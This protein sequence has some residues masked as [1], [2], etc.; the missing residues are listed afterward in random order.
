MHRRLVLLS[1]TALAACGDL[2]HENPFDPATPPDRQART[3]FS[4]RVALEPVGGVTPGLAG[5]QVSLAGTGFAAVTDA[6]GAYVITGVPPG[7][8]T[9]QAIADDYETG[10][11]AGVTA[12]LDTGGTTLSLPPLTLLR[13]RGDLIGEVRLNL[14]ASDPSLGNPEIETTGGATV[15]LEGAAPPPPGALIAGLSLGP[16]A[17]AAAAAVAVTDASGAYVIPDVP[18][19]IGSYTLTASRYGYV[20]QTTNVTFVNGAF[21]VET[22]QLAIDPGSIAGRAVAVGRV[23]LSGTPDSSG[24]TVRARGTTLGG[25]RYWREA[26]TMVDGSYVVSD[27]PA[28]TYTVSFE[29]PDHAVVTASA[30]VA[31]GLETALEEVHLVHD[32]GTLAGTVLLSGAASSAGAVVTA[33]NGTRSA[34]AVTDAAGAFSLPGLDTGSWQVVARKDPDWTPSSE[35]TVAV[36]RNATATLGATPLQP[37][38]TASIGGQALLERTTDHSLTTV[39]L[40]GTDF[41]GVA[42]PPGTTT[43]TDPSGS[44]SFTGLRAGS[45]Q[46]AFSHADYE[47]PAP[48]GVSLVTGQSVA[49]PPFTLAV[50]TGDV[51]GQVALSAGTA[52]GFTQG[53]D[54]SGVVVT[55]S[56]LPSGVAIPAAVTDASGAYRFRAV[57]VSTAHA[58]YA[59]TARLANYASG[60]GAVLV[61]ANATATVAPSPITLPVNAGS[62]TGNVAVN[63]TGTLAAPVNGTV[64][65]TLAGTAFNGTAFSAS[66]ANVGA[67]FSL[68]NLPAG[69]Y[70]LSATSAGR[71]CSA[72]VGVTLTPGEAL[73]LSKVPPLYTFTCTDAVAPGAVVLGVPQ[74]AGAEPGY[75]STTSVSVPIVSHA[76]D[77][78]GNLA[79]YQY[80]AGPVAN[81]TGAPVTAGLVNPVAFPAGTLT[82]DGTWTLW[83]RAVDRAG[84]AGPA[85]SVGVVYDSKNP[86]TPVLSTARAVVDATS[87][88]ITLAGSSVDANFLEYQ[89]ATSTVAATATCPATTALAFASTPATAALSLAANVKTCFWARA[90]DRAGRLSAQ[91]VLSVTSDLIP[92][93]S[94][95]IAP[96]Y[97]PSLLTVHAEYAD[98]FVTAGA[99]DAPAG[100][101]TPWKNVAWLEVDV[102]TGFQP[103]CPS[104][105]CRDASGVYN[106]CTCSCTDAR[107]VC[108]G[109]TFRA[110]RVPLLD[111]TSNSVGVRAVDLAGNVGS[112]ASQLVATATGN[113]PVAVSPYAENHP[114]GRGRLLGHRYTDVYLR[115]RDLGEDGRPDASDATCDIGALGAWGGVVPRI[116]VLGPKVVVHADGDS[117]LRSR[118]PGADGLFCSPAASIDDTWYDFYA[119][120]GTVW[121]RN[122]TGSYNYART[123]EYAAW[124]ERDQA[125]SADKVMVQ[126]PNNRG[127]LARSVDYIFWNG[128]M[129]QVVYTYPPAPAALFT[130]AAGTYVTDLLEGG[131][132]LLSELSSSPRFRVD[133]RAGGL[134]TNTGVT[135]WTLPTSAIAASLSSDGRSLAWLE[136]SGGAPLLHVR[137]AGA[138]RLYG[139]GDDADASRLAP[140][141]VPGS[142]SMAIE[143]SH[144]VVTEESTWEGSYWMLHWSAGPDGAF[145]SVTSDDD[146]VARVLPSSVRRESPSI[147]AGGLVAF[148]LAGANYTSDI[149]AADLST[150]RWERVEP[151]GIDGLASNRAGTLFYKRSG[152]LVARLPNGTEQQ[153]AIYPAAVAAAGTNLLTLE[154]SSIYLRRFAAGAWFGTPYLVHTG[155]IWELAAGGK[156]G[157][158]LTNEGG[159]R[160]RVSNL[161][162]A[163]PTA[164]LLPLVTGATPN[165]FIAV[166]DSLLAYQCG[167]AWGWDACVHHVGAD[168]VFGTADDGPVVLQRPGAGMSYA[169]AGGTVSGI[170]VYGNKIALNWNGSAYVVS[171]GADGVVNTG[172]DEEIALGASQAGRGN[173]DVAGDYA[174]WF[175]STPTGLQVV[176]V[177]LN[178]GTTRQLT[179]HYS[180]KERIT[181]DP[182][183]RLTWLDYGFS[184]P[185]I[186]L[187][188]P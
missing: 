144:V 37:V 72:A 111:G 165:G 22:V 90:L 183:G 133:C 161:S 139:T 78:S 34:S 177:D 45:Y 50:S 56:G 13:V 155:S 96:L 184:A 130:T 77:A 117:T 20:T 172:D 47:A 5:V 48:V 128:T 60:A 99:T 134:G 4:G 94:P 36:T 95:T 14:P 71:T 81:W 136:N 178:R 127:L 159:M 158:A 119:I 142:A 44:W 173:L 185:S 138:D 123:G 101:T 74:G 179:S 147:L 174:A 103:L 79:G 39:T 66:A 69:T 166:G 170:A 26:T 168:G 89:S 57:P 97:D 25:T 162:A 84:N 188:A 54:Y 105:S 68:A 180:M 104:T 154:G 164:T 131:D 156:W 18:A 61:L 124:L 33:T 181:L 186:F 62:I 88:S 182:S 109:T 108:D 46:V 43:T 35:S 10:H 148:N 73:A 3:A 15:T 85:S 167:S 98:F 24:I 176:Q 129:W 114:R 51:S 152:G 86:P 17:L 100:G 187:F 40:S 126:A 63:D 29:L 121:V 92:P 163:S 157:L 32:T 102:G 70:E 49:V 31:P 12:T 41:R 151:D 122:V 42:L 59:V 8:Y 27:L 175:R 106:P 9:L 150:Y 118:R 93:T 2:Q 153:A 116:A 120:P 171:A 141:A 65:L 55:L 145:S 67:S 6:A 76:T 75:V 64:T 91:A 107:L 115:L 58:A 16:T 87:A 135:T 132:C 21:V 149:L 125:T 30:S 80:V 7:T 11:L 160:L 169:A 23:D 110:I 143:G 113:F 52:A 137:S 1:V 140:G 19:P 82:A 146:T 38:A 112:G 53:T 83:V 28:G